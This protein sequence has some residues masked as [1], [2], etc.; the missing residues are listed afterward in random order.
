M[1]EKV[2]GTCDFQN[3]NLRVDKTQLS[4]DS[5]YRSASKEITYA[6]E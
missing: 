1:E 4:I 3:S 5:N 6:Y 2:K